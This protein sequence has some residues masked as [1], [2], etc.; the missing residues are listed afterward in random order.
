MPSIAP[1]LTSTARSAWIAALR[2]SVRCRAAHRR[3]AHATR[4]GFRFHLRRHRRVILRGDQIAQHLFRPTSAFKQRFLCRFHRWLASSGATMAL[5]RIVF[6]R[7]YDPQVLR[8]HHDNLLAPLPGP[9][10]CLRS[11][12]TAQYEHDGYPTLYRRVMLS[13]F[14]NAEI[15]LPVILC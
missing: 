15:G 12:I 7:H 14:G 13:T 5:S 6:V 4:L 1:F 9:N 8:F 3:P 10:H 2:P 11:A